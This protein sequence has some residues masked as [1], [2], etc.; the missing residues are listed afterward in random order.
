MTKPIAK[1]ILGSIGALLMALNTFSIG[2]GLSTG[3]Y[4]S[5]WWHPSMSN[6]L[7][8]F[9]GAIFGGFMLGMIWYTVLLPQ[10]STS[11]GG[12]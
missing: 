10:Q 7:L 1:R 12:K 3:V 2:A 11:T 5:D 4:Y 6:Q 9:F 8:I